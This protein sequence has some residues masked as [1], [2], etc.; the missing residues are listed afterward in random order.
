[1]ETLS[2]IKECR[3]D[4]REFRELAAEITTRSCCLPSSD[5][6]IPVT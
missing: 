3:H 5:D 2:S 6:N 1:M 4:E